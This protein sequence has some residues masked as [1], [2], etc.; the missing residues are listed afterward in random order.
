MKQ[1]TCVN[2]FALPTALQTEAGDDSPRV[3]PCLPVFRARDNESLVLD[4]LLKDV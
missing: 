2:S 4:S 3:T 1:F